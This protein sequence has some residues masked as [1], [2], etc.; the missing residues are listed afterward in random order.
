MNR[1]DALEVLD[2]MENGMIK[3]GKQEESRNGK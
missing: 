1:S 2:A 3:L